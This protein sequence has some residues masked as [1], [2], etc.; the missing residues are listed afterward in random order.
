MPLA[1]KILMID[2]GSDFS[3]SSFFFAA[4]SSGSLSLATPY[5][6][7]GKHARMMIRARQDSTS[8][9][10]LSL[11]DTGASPGIAFSIGTVAGGPAVSTIVNSNGY[12]ITISA[13]Q[14]LALTPTQSA[15]YDLFVDDP[16]L[17]T[18]VLYQQGPFFI[19]A[20]GTR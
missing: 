18:S 8:P 9:L 14:S 17:G 2:Q 11:L 13:A 10:I 12:R 3:D 6:L 7:A 1:N 16:A 4:D 20:T 19:R 5:N 15:Y